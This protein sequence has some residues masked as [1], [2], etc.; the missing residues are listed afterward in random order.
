MT[1]SLSFFL[2]TRCLQCLAYVFVVGSVA[3]TSTTLLFLYVLARFPWFIRHVKAEGAE[4]EVVHRLATF[5][6]LN[7]KILHFDWG[8]SF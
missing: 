8:E 2:L 3:G 6:E 1:S 4:P 5:Y 7:V